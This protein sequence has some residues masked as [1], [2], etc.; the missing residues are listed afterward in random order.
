MIATEYP[1]LALTL[2]GVYESRP[3]LK[4]QSGVLPADVLARS[5]QAGLTQ[6]CQTQIMLDTLHLQCAPISAPR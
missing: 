1:W 4:A 3:M 6:V 2:P 5:V